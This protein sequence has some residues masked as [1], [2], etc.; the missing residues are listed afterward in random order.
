MLNQHPMEGNLSRC[1]KFPSLPAGIPLRPTREIPLRPYAPAPL[2]PCERFPSLPAEDSL[3]PHEGDSLA[4]LR[5]IPPRP[6]REGLLRNQHPMEGDLSPCGR[7]PSIPTGDSPL[8][9]RTSAPAGHRDE[10]TSRRGRPE[11]HHTDTRRALPRMRDA[12]ALREEE[13]GASGATG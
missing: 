1:G 13:A 9:L 8:P 7:F 2:R 4:P 3:G 11:C 10:R 6:A 12:P 5:K